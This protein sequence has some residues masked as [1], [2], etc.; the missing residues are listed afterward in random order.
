MIM[1]KKMA[2]G[3]KASS[4]GPKEKAASNVEGLKARNAVMAAQKA[5]KV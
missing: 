4:G 1:A 2:A 3:V 5:S